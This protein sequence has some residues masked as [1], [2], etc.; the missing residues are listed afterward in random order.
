MLRY[1]W[2]WFLVRVVGRAP[3]WFLMA[4]ADLGGM[5]LWYASPRVRAVTTDHMRH[6][7]GTLSTANE[8]TRAAKGCVRT[9]GRYYADFCRAPHRPTGAAFDELDAVEGLDR[10]FEAL[11]RGCGLIV[12]SAH[13]GN[14]EFFVRAVGQLEIDLLV[15]TEPLSPPRVH[16]LVHEARAARGVRFMPAG[17]SAVREAITHLKQGGVLAVLGD[18]DVLHNGRPTVFF[19]ERARLPS[20]AVDLSLRTGAPILP[21]FVTRTPRGRYRVYIDEAFQVQR[22]GDHEADIEAGMRQVAAA[23]ETGIRRAPDQW[24]PLQP[25]WS[26]LAL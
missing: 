9:A 26:G 5:L 24:F 6:V 3:D 23:L 17:L 16:R 20:G 7:L 15:L 4:A 18:R 25:V 19:D 2:L 14:P 1:A 11:D 22:T 12:C 13:L 8:R 10:W 21:V